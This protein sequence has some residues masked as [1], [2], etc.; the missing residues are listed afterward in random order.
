VGI[1]TSP[2]SGSASIT[3]DDAASGLLVRPADDALLGVGGPLVAA[4]LLSLAGAALAIAVGIARARGRRTGGGG[5]G[6]A[7]YLPEAADGPAAPYNPPPPFERGPGAQ[8]GP[9]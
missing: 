8:Q 6:D 2:L 9:W 1:F 5:P 7:F 4:V 3:C